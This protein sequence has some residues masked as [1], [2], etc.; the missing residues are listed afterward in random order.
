MSVILGYLSD[1][2]I[3]R[4]YSF[5]VLFLI[6]KASQVLMFYYSKILCLK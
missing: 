2:E 3:L 1:L 4:L 6:V 5:K